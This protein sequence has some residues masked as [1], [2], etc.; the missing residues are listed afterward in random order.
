MWMKNG[1]R[2]YAR[3]LRKDHAIEVKPDCS[4]YG[5]AILWAVRP[6]CIQTELAPSVERNT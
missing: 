2:S 1:E 6:R 5:K 3:W 4:I